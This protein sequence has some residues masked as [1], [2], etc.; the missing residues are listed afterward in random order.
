[1]D[2]FQIRRN[3][4]HLLAKQRGGVVAL[5]NALERDSSQ[6]SRYLNAVT[7]IGNKMARH[8]ETTLLLPH[9]WLT[10]L[11]SDAQPDHPLTHAVCTFLNNSPDPRIAA[12]LQQ[13]LEAL[14]PPAP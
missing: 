4:L 6:I 8:V 1:M 14:T 11:H 9:G 10:Q 5:A 3:N 7:K 12:I 2:P 13:L